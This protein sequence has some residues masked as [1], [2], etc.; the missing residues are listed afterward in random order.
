MRTISPDGTSSSII[1]T[2]SST[3]EWYS[4]GANTTSRFVRASATTAVCTASLRFR[5]SFSA[6]LA[7]SIFSTSGATMSARALSIWYVRGSDLRW[8]LKY[9]PDLIITCATLVEQVS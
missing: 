2:S 1:F 5:P 6:T 3:S 7:F 9:P 4:F 8:A